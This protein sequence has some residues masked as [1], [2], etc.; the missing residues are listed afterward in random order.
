[1]VGTTTETTI[2]RTRIATIEKMVEPRATPIII[3]ETANAKMTGKTTEKTTGMK[4]RTD[5]KEDKKIRNCYI[6][7]S[8]PEKMRVENDTPYRGFS[9][10]VTIGFD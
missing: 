3:E 5:K 8:N 1:M 2:R 10:N 7:T 9:L 6:A 4:T